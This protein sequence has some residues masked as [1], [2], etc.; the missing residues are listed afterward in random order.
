MKKLTFCPIFQHFPQFVFFL[1]NISVSPV[2]HTSVNQQFD[3][4]AWSDSNS[5]FFQDY[6]IGGTVYF[7]QEAQ[8]I[9]GSF[10]SA[11]IAAINDYWL[12]AVI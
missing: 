9:A 2:P 8:I 11:I 10:H 1:L 4:K 12:D 7:Y 5:I 6:F 3:I